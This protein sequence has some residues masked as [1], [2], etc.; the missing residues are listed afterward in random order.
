MRCAYRNRRRATIPMKSFDNKKR[1]PRSKLARLPWRFSKIVS[2]TNC[3]SSSLHFLS[4]SLIRGTRDLRTDE[5]CLS[6]KGRSRR[7][8]QVVHELSKSPVRGREGERPKLSEGNPA[9]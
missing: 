9:C 4:R 2:R 3:S 8:W 5:A 1:K 6:R 7:H